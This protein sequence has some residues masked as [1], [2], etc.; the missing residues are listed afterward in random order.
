VLV[1]AWIRRRRGRRLAGLTLGVTALQSLL[2]LGLYRASGDSARWAFLL[3]HSLILIFGATLSRPRMPTFTW[4]LLVTWPGSWVIAATFLAFPWSI[5]GL[6]GW[7]APGWPL[8]IAI[9]MWG[10]VD[11]FVTRREHVVVDLARSPPPTGDRPLREPGLIS[12]SKE[13]PPPPLEN[14]LR[15]VQITD[16][17]LGPF[18]SVSRLQGVC[19]AALAAQPDIVLLTGDLLTL[20]SQGSPTLLSAALAP[21]R[22]HPQVW[23][24]PGNHDHETPGVIETSLRN[25]GCKLLIDRSTTIHTR[26]GPVQLVGIDF[27][28]NAREEA[29]Q[30]VIRACPND[31][32]ARWRLILLHDPS[33]FRYLPPASGD[34]VFSGHTHGGQLGLLSLGISWTILGAMGM[35]DFGAFQHQGNRMY[36]H[37]GQGFYGF[38]LRIGVPAE[39]SV[40]DLHPPARTAL[41]HRAD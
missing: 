28:W 35:P 20:A 13:P 17:H 18:M 21:L 7:L 4:R 27:R 16:P 36:V 14:R 24:I 8:P 23:A 30:T 29:V 38:P 19:K 1:W 32:N 15:V 5:A 9:A 40:M 3:S 12:R 31:A 25:I 10:L 33:M 26:V 6:F 2:T 39:D 34:L 11:T 41:G 22:G 37:R